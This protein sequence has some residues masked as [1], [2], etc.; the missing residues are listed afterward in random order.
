MLSAHLVFAAVK[1]SFY[2]SYGAEV[3]RA[4]SDTWDFI[5]A[6]ME[7]NATDTFRIPPDVIL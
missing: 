3:K 5:K 4:N 1:V 6:E 7:L 2:T